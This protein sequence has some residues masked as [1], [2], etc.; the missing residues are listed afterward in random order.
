MK[1]FIRRNWWAIAL[2]LIA[3]IF[4]FVTSP[5]SQPNRPGVLI[6]EVDGTPSGYAYKLK[7]S[8]GAISA[9]SDAVGTITVG[10]TALNNVS[11]PS[12]DTIIN[13][14]TYGVKFDWAVD[15]PSTEIR[16]EFESDALETD[17]DLTL[18]KWTVDANGTPYVVWQLKG[19]ASGIVDSGR[20]IINS[21]LL[22]FSSIDNIKI[23]SV[24]INDLDMGF[25]GLYCI[26]IFRRWCRL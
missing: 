5:E 4:L 8:N 9:L 13:M 20:R 10:N 15:D 24:S 21:N 7:F 3:A 17:T 19:T 12:A 23:D 18:W 2:W 26:S 14:G 25:T 1:Q 16:F 11:D 6:E 22:N